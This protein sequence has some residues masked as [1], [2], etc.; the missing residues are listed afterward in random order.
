MQPCEQKDNIQRLLNESED[1]KRQEGIFAVA[2]EKITNKLD[3]LE[4]KIDSILKTQ[5]D[6]RK[7]LLNHDRIIFAIKWGFVGAVVFGL[8]TKFGF[9]DL[10]YKL[11]T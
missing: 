6:D 5:K 11:F 7:M 3:S 9:W 4:E 8:A 1:R 2:I 10:L